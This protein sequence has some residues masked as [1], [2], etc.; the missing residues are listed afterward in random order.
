MI[1][2][3]ILEELKQKLL[4]EKSRIENTLS[5]TEA[6][7]KGTDREYETKF[8]EIERDEEENA[9]EMEMYESNLA[10]DEAMKTELDKIEKA[11][12]SMENGS[13]GICAK[14]QKEIPLER[15]RAYPQADTCLECDG[16]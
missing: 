14:C 6:D 10:A 3:K 2:P 12:V 5:K 11:L 1:D 16:K 7:K 8:P 4:E 9:D 13:Y 15:L